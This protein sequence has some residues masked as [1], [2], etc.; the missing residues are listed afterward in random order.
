M[1]QEQYGIPK[2]PEVNDAKKLFEW[3]LGGAPEVDRVIPL[4]YGPL[5]QIIGA[6]PKW[7]RD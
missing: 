5:L 3:V 6:A 2:D 7:K 4:P 1:Q